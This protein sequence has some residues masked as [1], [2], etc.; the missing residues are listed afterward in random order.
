[1]CR[2]KKFGKLFNI[3]RRYGQKFATYFFGYPVESSARE[4]AAATEI[5]AAGNGS[6]DPVWVS[7]NICWDCPLNE[8]LKKSKGEQQN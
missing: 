1:M 3:S 6:V 4:A 5:A 7:A 2:W 8:S